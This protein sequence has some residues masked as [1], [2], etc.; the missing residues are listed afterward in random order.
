MSSTVV[1][2]HA[3]RPAFVGTDPVTYGEF[4][5]RV[6]L[7]AARLLDLEV[8]LGDRL[9]IWME[10]KPRYAEAIL[11]AL[12]AGCAYVPLYG[13]QPIGRVTGILADSEPTVLFTEPTRLDALGR[14][15]LPASLRAIVVDGTEAPDQV[16]G[17][18][19]WRWADFVRLAAGRVTLMP[20]PAP[21]DLA[22]VLYTSGSTGAPKGVR[23]SHRN[24][25]NFVDWARTELDVGADDVF[26]NHAS[27]NFDLS[28]FDLFT[29]LAVGAAVWIVGDDQVRDVSALSEGIREHGVTVW[30]S[31]PSVL[32]LLS[33]SGCL[34]ADTVRSLRYV[35]FAGEEFPVPQLRELVG[36]LSS[37]TVLYNLYGP[38]ETNVCT[39]HRV[40]DADLR[41]EAPVP[42]GTAITGARVRV[43]D[44]NGHTVTDSDTIGELIVE[45]EC[46]TPG[47]WRRD[48]EP[49][50]EGHAQGR[51]HT[52]DLVSYD[53]EGL[54]VYRGRRDR[55]VKL[56]GYRVELGE[57]EAAVLEHPDI[58]DAAVVVEG[59]G[60]QARLVLYHTVRTGA[61]GPK[62]LQ[63]KQHCAD[64]LPHYMLPHLATRLDQL[65]RN[66]NGKTDYR[67]LHRGLAHS[68]SD[69]AGTAR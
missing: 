4:S 21:A 27:F 15:E 25:T 49:A 47:Y 43:V 59:S 69:P 50:A 62:L 42:M 32:N 26:A 3:D 17:V 28:T 2:A 45:G 29:A 68:T 34:T 12:H 55:M 37:A 66:A 36:R 16:S 51:H 41:R 20:T 48:G 13:A 19:V 11:A 31:V 39:F 10:K 5:Q 64:R 9:A 33:S 56:S 1:E 14:S 6:D 22:A 61:D 23:L 24:L 52:G 44:H 8:R 18:R 7:L 63:I 38:T 67:R 60:T 40:R 53:Q 65:P 54:L 30:Y 57:I 46:V 35:L 58:T